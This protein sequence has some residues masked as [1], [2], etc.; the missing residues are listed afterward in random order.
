MVGVDLRRY[1]R[2]DRG[3]GKRPGGT[4]LIRDTA[5][6][7]AGF[8]LPPLGRRRADGSGGPRLRG[9]VPIPGWATAT[10]GA[11]ATTL[12][13]CARICSSSPTKPVPERR[14]DT[15]T[16]SWRTSPFPGSHPESRRPAAYLACRRSR[17]LPFRL[18]RGVRHREGVPRPPKAG[19]PCGATA[20]R[21][22][23]T[24]A[25]DRNSSA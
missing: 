10:T 6:P 1:Q 19:A 20:G 25:L 15:S 11:P 8:Q 14:R 3:P 12:C 17:A 16:T 9:R 13:I 22:K 7:P 18:L 21:R 24:V 5:P 23:A 4:P 2:R